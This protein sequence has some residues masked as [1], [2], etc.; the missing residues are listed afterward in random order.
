MKIAVIG[1]G[2][3]GMLAAIEIAKAGKEVVLFEKNEKTGKKLFIT[4]KGRCNITNNCTEEEFLKNVIS[5][6]K[7][8]YRAIYSFPCNATMDFF[9]NLGVPLKTERGNRVFPQSDKSSDILKALNRALEKSK[10]KVRLNTEVK[11]IV[12]EENG[13]TLLST[14]K[15]NFDGVVIATGGITYTQTGSTGDGYKFA[16]EFGH[17]IVKPVGVLNAMISSEKLNLAGLTL[18]NVLFK[19]LKGKKTLYAEQGELLFTHNGISGPVVLSASSCI[20]RENFKELKFYID[21]KPALTNEVLDNRVLR[22]FEANK[23]RDFG[24][25]LNGL[26]PLSMIP[27]VIRRTGISPNKKVNSIT[28]EERAKLVDVLKNF[29]V[30][31]V[32]LADDNFGIITQGGINVKEINP[33][34]M[35]SKLVENLFFV[36]EALDVDAFTG[37]FNLQIALST[38]YLCGKYIGENL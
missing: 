23:N 10:V 13:F 9:E 5:N 35:M 18:K 31:V 30:K 38:G 11:D 1:G 7:F 17:T 22:D 6:P 4:G 24:N 36:G 37:G 27:V 29:E 20:A 26:L 28:K 16:R 25:S 8:L 12:K 15:E 32:A 34:N 2:P 3:A 19:V 21:L 14:H 33:S